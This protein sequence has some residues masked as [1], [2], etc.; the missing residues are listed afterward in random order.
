MP[1]MVTPKKSPPFGGLLSSDLD[2]RDVCQRY[3]NSPA[4]LNVTGLKHNNGEKR[5]V[6]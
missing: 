4:S 1:A 6:E 3:P 2:P 5:K